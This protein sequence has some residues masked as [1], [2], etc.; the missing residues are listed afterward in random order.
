MFVANEVKQIRGESVSPELVR[1]LLI[2]FAPPVAQPLVRP[3]RLRVHPGPMVVHPL[4]VDLLHV[5]TSEDRV[6]VQARPAAQVIRTVLLDDPQK[7]SP[8]SR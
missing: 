1:F 4:A 3:D 6:G 5:G 7:T 2:A 8:A